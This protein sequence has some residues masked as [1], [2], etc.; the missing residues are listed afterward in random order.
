[1]NGSLTDER[2][3]SAYKMEILRYCLSMGADINQKDPH[4]RTALFC[5]MNN[6]SLNASLL[7]FFVDEGADFNVRSKGETLLYLATAVTGPKVETVEW[8][9]RHGANPNTAVKMNYTSE[10]LIPLLHRVVNESTEIDA[11]EDYLKVIGLLMEYGA[12]PQAIDGFGRTAAQHARELGLPDFEARIN[13]LELMMKEKD[14]LEE[15]IGL[16]KKDHDG[17]VPMKAAVKRL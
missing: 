9:L 8:L 15:S 3:G 2:F 14:I 13:E 4:G 6:V 12:D 10:A 16:L 11:E 5:Y 17:G 7:Q 1:M